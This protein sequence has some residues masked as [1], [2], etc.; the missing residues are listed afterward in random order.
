MQLD[1]VCFF[2]RIKTT[3]LS[4]Q[5]ACVAVT[6]KC[7]ISLIYF[8]PYMTKILITSRGRSEQML[9]FLNIIVDFFPN[10]MPVERKAMKS[11]PFQSRL[12]LFWWF[13]PFGRKKFSS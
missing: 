4:C 12:I 1:D 6:A 5:V 7:F 10:A 11:C 13:L 8:V 3:V 9:R 2:F